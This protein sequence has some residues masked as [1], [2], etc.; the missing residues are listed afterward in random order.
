[1]AKHTAKPHKIRKVGILVIQILIAV[2]AALAVIA[3]VRRIIYQNQ[4]KLQE[5][6]YDDYIPQYYNVKSYDSVSSFITSM[7]EEG[8][9]KTP[10]YFDTENEPSDGDKIVVLSTCI[11]GQDDRRLLVVGKLVDTV[12]YSSGSMTN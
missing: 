7:K 6:I 5:N 4:L 9:K 12:M 1:M 10:D 3:I 8:T 11:G 2:L